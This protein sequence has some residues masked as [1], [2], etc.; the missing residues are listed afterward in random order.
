M[1]V[2]AYIHTFIDFSIRVC[3]IAFAYCIFAMNR[4]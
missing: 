2:H 4:T 1:S 3:V